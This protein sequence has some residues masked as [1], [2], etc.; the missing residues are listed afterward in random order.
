MLIRVALLLLISVSSLLVIPFR[1]LLLFSAAVCSLSLEHCSSLLL[2]GSLPSLVDKDFSYSFS[3]SPS[4]CTHSLSPVL[5]VMMKSKELKTKISH[6]HSLGPSL[7]LYAFRLSTNLLP[8]SLY[9]DCVVCRWSVLCQTLLHFDDLHTI[10]KG[11]FL[12]NLVRPLVQW[13]Q[14]K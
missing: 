10:H 13:L 12:T 5:V 4:P 9:P 2:C 8:S 1:S 11:Q 3:D 14:V 6:A 7:S